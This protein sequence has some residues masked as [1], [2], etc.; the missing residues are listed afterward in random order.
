MKIL[1]A[2]AGPNG[3]FRSL[4]GEGRH[5]GR[6]ACPD[7]ERVR[8]TRAAQHPPAGDALDDQRDSP[9]GVGRLND[10]LWQVYPAD[11]DLDGPGGRAVLGMGPGWRAFAR[12]LFGR[13]CSGALR[14]AVWYWR[15]DFASASRGRGCWDWLW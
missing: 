7:S 14:S 13:N 5:D 10:A 15:G 9:A 3:V 8:W 6:S 2:I 12:D 4:W 1:V 11:A